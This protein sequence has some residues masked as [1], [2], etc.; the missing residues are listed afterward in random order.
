M[1]KIYSCFLINEG[2]KGIISINIE[3][4]NSDDKN[5]VNYDVDRVQFC[6]GRLP[7]YC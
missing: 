4:N 7:F 3:N 6:K 5:T 2:Y 1:S